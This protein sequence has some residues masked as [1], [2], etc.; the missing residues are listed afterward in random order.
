MADLQSFILWLKESGVEVN[1]EVVELREA[2]TESGQRHLSVYAAQDL[3]V[4][5]NEV[6]AGI[7]KSACL[8]RLTASCSERL[9]ES[10]VGGALALIIA[11]I[12]EMA[13]RGRES[14]WK[15]Y[16]DLIPERE[17][18][19]PVFWS[20]DDLVYLE[21]TSLEETVAADK[22]LMRGDYDEIVVP[23]FDGAEGGKKA[24]W[25]AFLSAASLVA[26]RAFR[27][28]VSHGDGMVPVADLFT[29]RTDKENVRIYGEDS[30]PE[31]DGGEASSGFLE[32][33]VVRGALA[34][35]E[36]FNTFGIHG[37]GGLIHKYGE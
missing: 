32:M 31:T 30:D 22:A 11:V 13:V 24:T 15:P 19:L 37:N 35:Q 3:D 25:E 29:H 7:P 34:Q 26:S 20:D 16:F 17:S 5:S 14:R 6:A 18:S 1:G 2:K 33:I 27:V 21:G 23:F 9:A 10:S 28:D 8:T 12:H 36:V 4:S